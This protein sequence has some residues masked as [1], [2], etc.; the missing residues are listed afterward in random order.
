MMVVLQ[1]PQMQHM[2]FMWCRSQHAQ[3]CSVRDAVHC[4]APIYPC[5]S[6]GSQWSLLQ[7]GPFQSYAATTELN[8]PSEDRGS[9]G[10]TQGYV[11][12]VSVFS[13][14]WNFFI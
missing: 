10:R 4:S 2:I 8:I 5:V 11:V 13:R 7:G 1:M 6:W 12:I 3:V 14:K 9:E